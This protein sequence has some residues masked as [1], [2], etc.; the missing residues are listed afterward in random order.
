MIESQT[1]DADPWEGGASGRVLVVDD[2][3]RLLGLLTRVMR[4]NGFDVQC[5]FDATRGLELLDSRYDLVLLDLLM[6]G[7]DGFATL[8]RI[9]AERP[10]VAVIILSGVSEVD[11]KVRCFELGAADY[12]TKPFA[13]AEL[14]A[15]IRALRRGSGGRDQRWLH[16]GGVR[17]DLHS[18]Q[19]IADGKV[20]W[21]SAR[22]CALL[23]HLMRREGHVCT[24]AELLSAVWGY[25][26]DPGTNVV[27]VYVRRLRAKLGDR[28]VETVRS[29]GYSYGAR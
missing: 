10:D 21:L 9:R 16:D 26:F 17:L 28:I 24:R 12:V 7:E 18:H 13:M 3:P 27:D 25:S 8:R 2:E 14:L 4:A 15:R 1:A 19:A 6:P 23:A 29:V 11:S 5:A 22:E 20:V